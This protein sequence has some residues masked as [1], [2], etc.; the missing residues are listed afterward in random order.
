MG[1]PDPN[2]PPAVEPP[3]VPPVPTPPPVPPAPAPTAFDPSSLPQDAQDWL[4]KAAADAEAKARLGAKAGAAEAATKDLMA[5]MA[6]ALGLAPDPTLDPTKLAATLTERDRQLNTLK[7][8]GA[9]ERAARR[10]GGDDD[11]VV[12][13]LTRGGKLAALD[14]NAADFDS[15]LDAL[16]KSTIE[17][18]P[19]LRAGGAPAPAP[20]AQGATGTSFGAGPGVGAI[21][22]AQL[23]AMSPQEK[24]DALKAGKLAHLM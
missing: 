22:E 4:K 17:A 3:A 8:E 19:R 9:A 24:V 15:V 18:N 7:V 23:Q 6:T 1:Q 5:K 11:L 20:G 2:T 16:V 12:A 10:H 14:P 21:T 13:V